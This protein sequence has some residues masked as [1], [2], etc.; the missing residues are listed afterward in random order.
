MSALLE[1]LVALSF[2]AAGLIREVYATPFTVD[3]KGPD[4]PVTSAD[5]RAN[6]LIC[7]RLAELYP[8]VPIVAEESAPE[9]FAAYRTAPRIF[10]V[11]PLD[12][13]SEFVARNGQFVVMIGVVEGT[14]ATAGVVTA[15]ADWTAWA[16]EVETGAFHI[17][18]NG[19]REKIQVSAVT[20]V[21]DAVLLASR[22][23]RSPQLE[24][25]LQALG[26]RETR[27]VGSAGLKGAHVATGVADGYV[28]TG[29]VGKRWDACAV[30]ALV[31]AAGGRFTDAL[32]R[33]IDYRT[34]NLANRDGIV[35][36][37]GHLHAAIVE[38]LARLSA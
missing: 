37:N 34:E 23:H 36:T 10:F 18:G 19:V 38:R 31:T 12:G 35:A 9:S 26:A 21:H 20:Q 25:A 33:P 2:E 29:R 24:R 32:G 7:K 6:E 1:H 8:G 4:D 11:D 22:S 28:A 30:D 13:T 3:L 15:P 27:S 17:D 16:G 5:L 14:R